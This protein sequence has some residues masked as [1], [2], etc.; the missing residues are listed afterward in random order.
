MCLVSLDTLKVQHI[1]QWLTTCI[2]IYFISYQRNQYAYYHL[3]K[4]QT[5]KPCCRFLIRHLFS[6]CTP[7]TYCHWGHD[8]YIFS[9]IK[10]TKISSFILVVTLC[11]RAEGKRTEWPRMMDAG[12]VMWGFAVILSLCDQ[13]DDSAR[14]GDV[15][16]RRLI[17]WT[18]A[19]SLAV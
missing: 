5:S 11:W 13:S 7:T 15:A 3:S 12:R 9:D 1:L 4:L 8:L 2:Y 18:V 6:L 14:L 19:P 10:Q 16:W 17:S